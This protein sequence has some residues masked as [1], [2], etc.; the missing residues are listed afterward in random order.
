MNVLLIFTYG[1]SLKIWDETGLLNREIGLY[2]K[3]NDTEEI[4]FTFLTFGN[5]VD[6]QYDDLLGDIKIFPIYS[7][8]KFHKNKIIRFLY[9]FVICFK[10]KKQFKDIEI[11]K[12]N[13]LMGAWMAIALK[14]LI[15]CKLIIIT[16][17]DI[18]S[19]SIKNKKGLHKIFFYYLLTQVS[20]LLSNYYSVTSHSDKKFLNRVFLFN[21]DK[22]LVR[23]NWVFSQENYK[24]LKDRKN[25]TIL[26]VGRL[27]SQKNFKYLIQELSNTPISLD[28]VGH[29]SEKKDLFDLSK[30]L[31][32]KV[33]F[34]D[35]MPNEKLLKLMKDYK[36][37]V[38]PSIFEGNP[39]SLS[40]AMSL[41]CV[42][43]V[44]DIENNR[45]LV[46]HN[47]NGLLFKLEKNELKNLLSDLIENDTLMEK[48]SKNSV[49]KIEEKL[50][51]DNYCLG[52]INDYRL[53][54]V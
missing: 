26:S 40:E 48:L 11:I 20:L 13:Q 54:L 5:E 17:Y 21:K 22:L 28:I 38:L 19:V 7:K 23:P 9:T 32:V 31:N 1:I 4:N 34:I 39:K 2:K 37:F 36:I 18:L 35:A 42:P 25:N 27:E 8:F 33:N 15:G 16:G 41:G 12:T 46:E 14:K 6:H 44:S 45:E 30:N 24:P 52:E 51:L 50:S 43:V 47:Q 10:L 29:G 3:L 53:L 49:Y